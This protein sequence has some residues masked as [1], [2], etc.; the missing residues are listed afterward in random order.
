MMKDRFSNQA[1]LYAAFRPV[2]PK[3]L[4]QFIMQYVTA[5]DLAWDV[6]TGNGQ[7]AVELSPYFTK[8][9][10]TDTSQKQIDNAIGADNIIY[11]VEPAEKSSLE[12]NSVNLITVAQALHWFDT[13]KFYAEAKR[14]ATDNAVIAVW[15]YNLLESDAYTDKIIHDFH[16]NILKDYWDPER[17]HVINNYAA[18]PFPFAQLQAPVFYIDTNWV[19]AQ[20][21]GYLKTWSGLQKFITAG[22]PDPI[23][24]IMKKILQFW[25]ENE[26]RPVRFP[27]H[28]KIARIN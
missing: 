14:V 12:K 5:H 2:Y 6:A 26:Q 8:V 17:K 7:S 18:I 25:P 3:S 9:M 16:F 24:A 27:L 20:L 11:K 4:F 10:A 28:V 13:A 15:T 22:N 21:E 19:P 1:G 23:E